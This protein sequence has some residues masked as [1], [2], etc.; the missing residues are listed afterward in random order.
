MKRYTRLNGKVYCLY[1]GKEIDR[2]YEEF[3]QYY[4]CGC[5]DFKKDIMIDDKISELNRQRPKAKYEL[6]TV[7]KLTK[8]KG[9]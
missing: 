3:E 4:E 9:N 5:E 2:S 8:L 1:C 7:E 6:T